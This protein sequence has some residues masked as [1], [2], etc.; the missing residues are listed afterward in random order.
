MQRAGPLGHRGMLGV[1]ARLREL[2]SKRLPGLWTGRSLRPG[3]Q[4][5]RPLAP[6]FAEPPSGGAALCPLV[7][8]KPQRGKWPLTNPK[9]T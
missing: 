9:W 7:F 8:F 2:R 1:A 3:N 5:A 4:A 6:F